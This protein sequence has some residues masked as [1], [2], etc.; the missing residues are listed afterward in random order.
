MSQE[1]NLS[2]VKEVNILDLPAPDEEPG[3]RCN[4]GHPVPFISLTQ[5]YM[6]TSELLTAAGALLLLS[7]CHVHALCPKASQLCAL[8]T[9]SRLTF[10]YR[11]R[12]LSTGSSDWMHNSVAPADVS[13]VVSELLSLP[14]RP[15]WCWGS[16]GS[17]LL[18][19][20]PGGM[21][22]RAQG[23]MLL[24]LRCSSV[25]C[26]L[27][28]NACSELANRC[29]RVICHFLSTEQKKNAFC[30]LTIC[31]EMVLWVAT[32]LPLMLLGTWW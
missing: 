5:D 14:Y 18:L 19:S 7:A 27:V 28:F 30:M 1:L 4:D 29:C 2:S 11:I 9:W 20:R 26:S 8:S 15:L 25:W 21:W 10:H 31:S 22:V 12:E 24:L 17:F 16:Q 3:C 32:C 6:G 23:G 13:S